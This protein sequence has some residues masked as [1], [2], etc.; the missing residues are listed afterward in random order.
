M[1]LKQ[2][3]ID[4]LKFI[5]YEADYEDEVFI[6]ILILSV[7]DEI[8]ID[9]NI[10]V[11]PEE[12]N[13]IVI[14]RTV[15]RFLEIRAS[16]GSLFETLDISYVAKKITEGDTTVEM[17]IPDGQTPHKVLNDLIKNLKEYGKRQIAAYRKIKW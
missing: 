7:V 1:D 10:L 17:A 3:V 2:D 5:G 4:Y 9:C 13:S 12:L 14:K 8:K 6:S 16:N 11:L 15:G